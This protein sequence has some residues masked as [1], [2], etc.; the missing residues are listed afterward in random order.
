MNR[1][2]GRLMVL[3]GVIAVAQPSLAQGMKKSN[4]YDVSTAG[5]GVI[6]ITGTPAERPGPFDWLSGE[7][8]LTLRSLVNGIEKA[9][10]DDGLRALVLKLDDAALTASQVEEIVG[11]IQD[12][13]DAGKSVYVVADGYNTTGLMLAAV[14]DESIVHHGSPVSLPG[15]YMEQYFL[16]DMFD[17]VGVD[18]SFEQVGEYKGADETYTRSEPSPEWQQNISQLLDS[19]YGNVREILKDGNKMSDSELDHAMEKAFYTSAESAVELDLLDRSTNLGEL[20]DMLEDDLGA[21]V[22]WSTNLI[23]EGAGSSF[24]TSNP[25]A[26]FS[27][28]SKDPSNKPVRPTI[29]VV[30]IDGVIMDGDSSEGGLFGSKSV[31]SR[32]IRNVL[33]EV[34][35][36]ELI[37][38]VVVRINSPGGSATASEVIWRAVREVAEEKPVYVSVGNMAASGGYYIAVSGDKIFV[39]PSSIVGSIGVVGGK[40]AME[41][42]YNKLHINVVGQGRGPRAELFGSSKPWDASQRAAV[43]EMMTETY[44]LFTSRVTEGRSGIDLDK[45]ARGRLFTGNKAIGL[46]MADEIGSLNDTIESLAD[47]LGMSNYD[48]LDYPGPM[49]LDDLMEQ[50]TGGM[51]SSPIKGIESVVQGIVG[52]QAW[53]AVR[54]RIDGAIMLQNQP[55]MLMD[56]NILIIR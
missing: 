16:K 21:D 33:K 34:G 12:A 30:H 38:G 26:I 15:L 28:L 39:N 44:D 41:G 31:G 3:A 19:M 10:A 43:R 20:E 14:A 40:L 17:W 4:S 55:V 2:I 37:K 25:F 51:V 6:T 46:K 8:T 18:A 42:A 47:E 45:T 1:M 24:D 23:D 52:P 29:A 36:N 27:M 9:A 35:D 48:V 7:N 22:K 56:P 49:S 32:T 53:P 54:Q 13:Q 11:A 50:F 5:V